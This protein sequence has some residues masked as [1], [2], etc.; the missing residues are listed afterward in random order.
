MKGLMQNQ[1][2]LLSFF[3]HYN[4]IPVEVIEMSTPEK[5][6]VD[7]KV[8]SNALLMV[9]ET[10]NKKTI[11]VGT[12]ATMLGVDPEITK[13]ICRAIATKCEPHIYWNGYEIQLVSSK[14]I[15]DL[16]EMFFGE[17]T[18]S[19]TYQVNVPSSAGVERLIGTK[20]EYKRIPGPTNMI[21]QPAFDKTFKIPNLNEA[22]NILGKIS[23]IPI[24]RA[25]LGKKNPK[26]NKPL[27]FEEFTSR[28]KTVLNSTTAEIFK[29]CMQIAVNEN[30][31]IIDVDNLRVVKSG[32]M[33]KP[34]A[35]HMLHRLYYS[36]P[37]FLIKTKD[38]FFIVSKNVAKYI[39]TVDP[40]EIESV[41]VSNLTIISYQIYLNKLGVVKVPCGTKRF[42]GYRNP[43]SGRCASKLEDMPGFDKPEGIKKFDEFSKPIK[44]EDTKKIEETPK[45]IENGKLNINDYLIKLVTGDPKT[46]MET[47]YLLLEDD[48]SAFNFAKQ[49]LKSIAAFLD[50]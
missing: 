14:S 13:L 19:D 36:L 22:A 29:E 48:P 41:I 42:M 46:M 8:L 24:G 12:M 50:R 37:G 40:R 33:K 20:C 11:S 44:P 10:F 43:I 9:R 16:D 39:T 27:S 28:T 7:Y 38:K 5:V 25:N 15:K 30:D 2:L 18:E 34:W 21:I 49:H 6:T 3:K 47:V 17:K 31:P 26:T 45:T 35:S 23:Q 4:L 32:G 1:F